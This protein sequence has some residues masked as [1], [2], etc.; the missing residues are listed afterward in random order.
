MPRQRKPA[1][2]WLRPARGNEAAVYI[3]LDGPKQISTSCGASS[4]VEAENCLAEYVTA[5]YKPERRERDINKVLVA[6]V[7]AIYL[8]DVAPGQARPEKAAERGL[9]LLEFFGG[10]TLDE[11]TG[12]R[13]RAYVEWRRG[14]G[15]SNKGT[16]GGSK[17]DLED[18]RAAIQHHHK[19]GL[20]RHIVRVALPERGR[21]RQRWM[22]RDELA[23]LLWACWTYRE[24]Q[25]GKSTGKRPLRHLCRFLLL[26]IYTGSRPGAILSA[27]WERGEGLSHVDTDRG[28]FHR[29]AEG[30]AETDKRQPTVKLAPGLLAHMRRWKRIDEARGHVVTFNGEPLGSVKT[31]LNHAVALSGIE[32]G[33]TAYTLR[34]TAATWLVGKGVPTKKIADFLGTS[35]A[36]ITRHYGHL[37]PGYQDEAADAIGR[38]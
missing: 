25:N 28:L 5:K 19:E 4:R 21:A 22:S 14:K 18:L 17:R 12:E 20:H 35:E 27:S 3:I 24:I 15:R 26:G 16:T 32:H 13:C 1:R 29:Q 33:V 34:H 10:M 31:G 38:K 30:K 37:V 6:D 11:I 23:R 8:T 7:I 36:M 2:L 9:R